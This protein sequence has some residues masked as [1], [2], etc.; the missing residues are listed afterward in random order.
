MAEGLD[1]ASQAVG[2]GEHSGVANESGGVAHQPVEEVEKKQS[3]EEKQSE[4][5]SRS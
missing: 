4:E 5:C 2:E 1:L 3:V